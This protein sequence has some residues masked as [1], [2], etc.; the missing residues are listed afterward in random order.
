MKHLLETLLSLGREDR[1][2]LA[3]ELMKSLRP[4]DAPTVEARARVMMEAMGEA[5]GRPVEPKMRNTFNSWARAIVAYTL[6]TE[7]FSETAIGHAL[8]R[9]H[10]TVN[11]MKKNVSQA[12]SYPAM[13]PDVVDWYNRFHAVLNAA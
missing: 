13:Y 9:D 11:H 5:T 1:A 12:L 7:G 2:R 3:S 8:N 4:N 10:S 6:A